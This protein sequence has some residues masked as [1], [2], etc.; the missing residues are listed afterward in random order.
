MPPCHLGIMLLRRGA[1]PALEGAA[2]E[3]LRGTGPHMA[4]AY[5]NVAEDPANI[6][7]SCRH[8]RLRWH[9]PLVSL[10]LPNYRQHPSAAGRSLVCVFWSTP[11]PPLMS[12]SQ[13]MAALRAGTDNM[14]GAVRMPCRHSQSPGEL[15]Q[16]PFTA[17]G[18]FCPSVASP[19]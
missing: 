13:Q 18:A 6:P 17:T 11:T 5:L 9:G 14:S 8:H 10:P 16:A 2:E 1:V 15:S 7:E 4:Q 19:A 3:V 12:H